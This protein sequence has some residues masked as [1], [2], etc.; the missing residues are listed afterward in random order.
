MRRK[1]VANRCRKIDI[2]VA[3]HAAE[4]V[5]FVDNATEVDTALMKA[6]LG[7]AGDKFRAAA[8][9]DRQTEW[10]SF[11]E[12]PTQSLRIKSSASPWTKG[13]ICW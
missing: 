1:V 8:G 11:L 2:G 3:G 6:R 5:V 12:F 7:E 10:R 13:P 4:G 9:A